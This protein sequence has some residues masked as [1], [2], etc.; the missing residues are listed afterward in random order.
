GNFGG[1]GDFDV[2][3]LWELQGLGMTNLA[4]IKERGAENRL[5]IVQLFQVQDRIAAEVVQAHAQAQAAEARLKEAESGLTYAVDSLEKN[6]ALITETRRVGDVDLLLVRP[7][8][9]LQ[10]LQALSQG[11]TDYYG[12]A[13][14]SSIAQLRPYRA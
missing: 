13:A 7:Q 10:A 9:V 1:R 5:A 11:Y 12:P 3:V 2:Q 4:R 14:D 8:E 6:L